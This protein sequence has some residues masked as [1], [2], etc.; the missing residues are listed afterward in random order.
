MNLKNFVAKVSHFLLSY[1]YFCKNLQIFYIFLISFSLIR[2]YS[3][4]RALL[5]T[6]GNLDKNAPRHKMSR[7]ERNFGK[8]SYLCITEQQIYHEAHT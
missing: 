8:K 4:T 3:S 5:Q 6:S 2:C 1:K 7:K